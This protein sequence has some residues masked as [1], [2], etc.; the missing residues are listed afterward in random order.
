MNS[1]ARSTT[2]DSWDATALKLWVSYAKGDR[3]AFLRPYTLIDLEKLDA[4]LAA[5]KASQAALEDI[6][7]LHRQMVAAHEARDMVRYSVVSKAVH[8]A[9][10]AAAGSA[11]GLGSRRRC[12]R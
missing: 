6:A 2:S 3:E 5:E 8:V 11:P 1:A 12:R 7:A 4:D 9:I 10:N